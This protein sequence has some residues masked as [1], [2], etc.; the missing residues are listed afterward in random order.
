MIIPMLTSIYLNI[1]QMKNVWL[2]YDF[3]LA[4]TICDF[5]ANFFV[6]SSLVNLMILFDRLPVVIRCNRKEALC[7]S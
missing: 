5:S 6:S 2:K 3:S 4:L 1:C 7:A